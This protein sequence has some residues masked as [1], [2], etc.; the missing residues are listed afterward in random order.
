[1]ACG[2]E[3]VEP[4]VVRTVESI[5]DEWVG[6]RME[7]LVVVQS[8]SDLAVRMKKSSEHSNSDLVYNTR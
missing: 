8:I 2:L 1:M 5:S 3:R 6:E 4:P 7:A